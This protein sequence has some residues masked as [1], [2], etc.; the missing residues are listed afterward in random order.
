M[1]TIRIGGCNKTPD[2]SS[3]Y[4]IPVSSFRSSPLQ[5]LKQ[6]ELRIRIFNSVLWE[7]HL[8]RSRGKALYRRL[9][10]HATHTAH[11]IVPL[12]CQ[13]SSMLWR[14]DPQGMKTIGSPSVYRGW[15]EGRYGDI[16][17]QCGH[18]VGDEFHSGVH[19]LSASIGRRSIRS[20]HSRLSR[21]WNLFR[22]PH[23]DNLLV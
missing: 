5:P 13:T 12:W 2:I 3:R 15:T 10:Y 6:S 17:K 16:E 22:K 19:V 4:Y 8:T 1:R 18:L 14:N 9:G 20:I 7:S 21:A 23:Y 11:H